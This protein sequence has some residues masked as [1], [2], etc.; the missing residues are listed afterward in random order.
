M[1]HKLDAITSRLCVTHC[2]QKFD[3]GPR[4]LRE[5]L[6]EYKIAAHLAGLK[7]YGA[8]PISPG[9]TTCRIAL[10]D[11]DSHKGETSWEDMIAVAK[12]IRTTVE[13]LGLLPIPFRSSGGKGIHMY[14]IWEKPQDAY[15]VRAALTNVLEGCGYKNGTA[16]V[17]EKQIEIFPKQASVP[18]D[19]FR[20]AVP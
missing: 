4:H 17:K 5:P 1:A 8:C 12:E 9:E 6:D 3:D 19:G 18:A 13:L 15:S 20:T 7:T 2:W 16:G 10:L 14:F 11:L